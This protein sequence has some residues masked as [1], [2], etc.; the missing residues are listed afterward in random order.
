MKDLF[1]IIDDAQIILKSKGVFYQKKLYRR[2]DRLYAG[3]G[4]GYI[5]I[6]GQS[7]TSCPNVSWESMDLPD[8]LVLAKG[9][10]GAP[11]IQMYADK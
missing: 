2:G 4:A 11:V 9:E 6:G 7:A 5:R 1:H 8:H 3:W 10:L